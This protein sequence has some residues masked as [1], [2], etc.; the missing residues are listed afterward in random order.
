MHTQPEYRHRCRHY[1][2]LSIDHAAGS[3]S[4]G[5][6][7]ADSPPAA[8]RAPAADSSP[9]EGSPADSPA[10]SPAAAGY[11]SPGRPHVGGSPVG[12]RRV[13]GSSGIVR[14]QYFIRVGGSTYGLVVVGVV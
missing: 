3:A 4:A 13:E 11:S 1:Y 2:C 5:V 14:G 12:G 8:D 10:D 7:A 6:G 9:A